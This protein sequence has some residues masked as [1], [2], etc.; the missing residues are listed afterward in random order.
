MQDDTRDD[1]KNKILRYH[2]TITEYPMPLEGMK[3]RYNKYLSRG[4]TDP[5]NE[6]LTKLRQLHEIWPAI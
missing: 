1:I 5:N 2:D 6:T 4:Y 3:N